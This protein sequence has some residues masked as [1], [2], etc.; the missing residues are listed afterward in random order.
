MTIIPNRPQSG[1]PRRA[2]LGAATATAL[3]TLLAGTAPAAASPS[4]GPLPAARRTPAD[5]LPALRAAAR[6]LTDLRPLERMTGHA[7]I[8]GIGEATHN[9]REFFRTKNRIFQRLVERRG[10]TAFA[11][12][13]P[14][15][16][17]LRL[18]SWVVRGEGDIERIMREEFQS[19]Y[20]LWRT[21]EFLDLFRWMREHNIRHPDRP[22]RFL[23][24]DCAYAGPEL[25]D[26][27]TEWV[28]V[29]HP[30]L[31][32]R[33]RALYAASRPTG[34]VAETID[35][36]LVRPIEERRAL[37]K[38]V[39]RALEL[40]RAAPAGPRESAG[41]RAWMLQH[42]HAIAQVGRMHSYDYF[43]A[44]QSREMM[45][46]RDR[47]MA[48]NTVWWHRATGHKVLLSAHNEHVGYEPLRPDLYPYVQ[49]GFIR[50]MVGDGYVSAG[51]TFGEGSFHALD[52]NTPG[53][54][55][56]RF[57]VGPPGPGTHEEVLGRVSETDYYLDMRT[58]APAARDR[59][60][61]PRPVRSIGNSWPESPVTARLLPTYDVLIHLPRIT[62][63]DRI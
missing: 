24:N 55:V 34:S 1:P 23:G 19:T 33:I 57:S 45:R 46:Y 21:R 63:A 54:P 13:A 6:P 14:W 17:G 15:S 43:N 20:F 51:F 39:R 18:D 16:T 53:E 5:P 11:L 56:R 41:E 49:G 60:D 37:A 29:R 50:D 25:F 47:I 9:S 62:A 35:G 7:S 27:V 38:D 26:R 4:S 2:V 31:S 61:L 40:L 28:A 42:A 30:A 59:L 12:E 58:A 48:R 44:S 10:F 32:P 36:Y 52:L 3:G 22:V 8:V